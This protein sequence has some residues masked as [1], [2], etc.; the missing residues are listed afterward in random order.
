MRKS[1]LRK[2]RNVIKIYG[3]YI[4][5]KKLCCETIKK[6][7]EFR[8]EKKGRSFKDGLVYDTKET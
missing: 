6:E 1:L 3:V 5:C 7:T 8:E 4:G 2:I